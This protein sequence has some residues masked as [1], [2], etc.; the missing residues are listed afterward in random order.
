MLI[1]SFTCTLLLL[2]KLIV[3]IQQNPIVIYQS[4]IA[5]Q[6]TNIP[7]PAVTFC[8]GLL[9]AD[10]IPNST[11]RDWLIMLNLIARNVVN[12]TKEEE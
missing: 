12:Y 8:P 10:K 5:T 1:V 2:N 11:D 6:V 3:K 9:P 7:F 4:D